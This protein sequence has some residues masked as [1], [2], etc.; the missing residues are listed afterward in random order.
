[1]D[2]HPKDS[3]EPVLGDIDELETILM[4]NAID[5]VVIALPVKSMYDQIQKAIGIC[6]RL[7]TQ[8]QYSI[9][10]FAT[11]ITKRRSVDPN[12]PSL[13]LLH[14]IHNETGM[15]LKRLTDII[16]A[17]MS[18][19]L[20]SP[21]MLVLALCV[22]M[23]SKGPILFRQPRYGLNRRIFTMLKFRSMVVNAELEQSKLEHLNEAGGP[24]FKMQSDP[25][26]TMVGRFIRKTS[27]DELPQLWNVLV[28]DMS[29]VG[30]RPL[31][32]RD[33]SRFS[34]AWLMRRFSVPPGITGLWQVSGRS[35]TTFAHW[36]TLDLEYID[37]WSLLLDFKILAKTLPAVLRGEG[38]V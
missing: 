7:G 12:D 35:K 10:L 28:G 5:E 36:I 29:L 2:P 16:F 34:E 24:V 4:S 3:S 20:L 13:I 27:L 11:K 14:M 15:A 38:A 33:V 8:S 30:P 37:R 22:R 1:V 26:V 25:R 21:L 19:I 32:I 31:P 18:L 6:E 17:G 9:D 23:S